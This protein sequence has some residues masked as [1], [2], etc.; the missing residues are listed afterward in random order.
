MYVTDNQV[1]LNASC[2]IVLILAKLMNVANIDSLL[3]GVGRFD[4]L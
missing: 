1:D 4:V 2:F 3:G